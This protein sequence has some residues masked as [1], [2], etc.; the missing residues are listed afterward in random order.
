[1]KFYFYYKIKFIR[2]QLREWSRFVPQQMLYQIVYVL[3]TRMNTS[4]VGG[5]VCK[6]VAYLASEMIDLFQ[7][8]N[9]ILCCVFLI[10]IYPPYPF[11]L[12]SINNTN[13]LYEF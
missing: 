10:S 13:I 11:S 2:I 5:I 8:D 4:R 1:M 9:T 12:S 7:Y 6:T 3:V